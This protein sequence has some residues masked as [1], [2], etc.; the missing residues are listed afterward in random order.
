I[1]AL[2]SF[3]EKHGEN[4]NAAKA[5]LQ[6][7]NAERDQANRIGRY[8][9]LDEEQRA[10]WQK[11]VDASLASAETVLEKFPESEEVALVLQSLLLTQRLQVVSALKSAEQVEQYFAALAEK[12]ADKPTAQSKIL[13]TQA[14]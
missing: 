7:S 9:V 3:V 6:I 1:A 11:H 5:L 8:V 12:Y 2:N 13:F 14:A 4:P 10:A